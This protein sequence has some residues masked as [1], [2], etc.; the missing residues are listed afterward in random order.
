MNTFKEYIVSTYEQ[1]ELKDIAE[2]GCASAA[3]GG[4]I[5]YS[6]TTALYNQHCD[7]LHEVIGEWVD[8]IGF[9]PEYIAENIGDAQTFKNS[10]VWAVAEYYANDILN[11]MECNHENN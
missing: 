11:D 5:Y 3:P 4:M 8:E 2:H 10:I 7:E 1:D 9:I 6:E